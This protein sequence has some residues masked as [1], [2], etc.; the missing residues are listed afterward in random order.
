MRRP[1]W[2]ATMPVRL[3]RRRSA[4]LDR[5]LIIVLPLAALLLGAVAT[6]QILPP[7]ITPPI[8]AGPSG[9]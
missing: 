4:V 2:P 7:S 1:L 3:P 9:R 6:A 8:A 5:V